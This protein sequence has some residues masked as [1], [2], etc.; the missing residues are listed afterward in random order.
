[1][2]IDPSPCPEFVRVIGPDTSELSHSDLFLK[3]SKSETRPAAANHDRTRI[4][5]KS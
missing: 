4:I 3:Q 2:S 5:S 1:M